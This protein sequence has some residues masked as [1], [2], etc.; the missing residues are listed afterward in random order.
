MKASFTVT[1]NLDN[2]PGWGNTPTDF[3]NHIQNFLD[4]T[5]PHYGGSVTTNPEPHIIPE[6]E[7]APEQTYCRLHDMFDCWMAHNP[8]QQPDAIGGIVV[9]LNPTD[10]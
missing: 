6:Q 2:V 4:S 3:R 7:V 8:D 10:G 9:N 1:V 5:I